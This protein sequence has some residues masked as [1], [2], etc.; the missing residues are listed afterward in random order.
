MRLQTLIQVAEEIKRQG[1][2]VRLDTNGHAN[3][4]HK[5][6]IVPELR[7][8]VDTVSISLNATDA[9]K[10]D[11]ICLPCIENAYQAML[12]FTK[13]CVGAIPKVILSVVDVIGDEE[14]RKAQEIAGTLGATLRVRAYIP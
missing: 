11:A 9:Q 2:P 1:K 7:G 13:C 14:I 12:D 3:A 5:R 4:I 10:Y 6:N 8:L